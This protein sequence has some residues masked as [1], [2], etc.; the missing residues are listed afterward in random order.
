[1]CVRCADHRT[2]VGA[3]LAAKSAPRAAAAQEVG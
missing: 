3:Q 2:K 1:M